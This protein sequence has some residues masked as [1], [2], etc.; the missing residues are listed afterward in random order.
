MGLPASGGKGGREKKERSGVFTSGRAI[1]GSDTWS[2]S[3]TLKWEG[4]TCKLS[5]REGITQRFSGKI[6]KLRSDQRSAWGYRAGCCMRKVPCMIP[7]K[8]DGGREPLAWYIRQH[9]S[10]SGESARCEHAVGSLRKMWQAPHLASHTPTLLPEALAFCPPPGPR[11]SASWI[12]L[13]PLGVQVPWIRRTV[14]K[15]KTNDYQERA[16]ERMKRQTYYSL[17]DV[18]SSCLCV[19]VCVYLP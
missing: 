15:T 14:Y 1:L 12:I 11:P 10:P 6:L 7:G 16:F 19:C 3:L 18:L 8:R 13:I 4:S 2:G 17:M 5:G 9:N